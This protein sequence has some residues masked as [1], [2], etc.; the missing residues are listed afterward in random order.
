MLSG[1][2]EAHERPNKTRLVNYLAED[3]NGGRT[4]LH[5]A[6]DFG[7]LG[8]VRL[9]LEAGA[10]PSIKDDSGK[11]A[12]DCANGAALGPFSAVAELLAGWNGGKDKKQAMD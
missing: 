2:V 4:A 11:T 3:C 7:R 6:A 1:E 9:L 10:D 12:L 8:I 5:Y